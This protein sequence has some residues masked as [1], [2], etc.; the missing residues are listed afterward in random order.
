M[1][2]S[3]P[4]V[5]VTWIINHFNYKYL[6]SYTCICITLPTLRIKFIT[7]YLIIMMLSA[8]HFDVYL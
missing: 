2:M 1:C 3:K 6:H 7:G 4:T 8:T 5:I